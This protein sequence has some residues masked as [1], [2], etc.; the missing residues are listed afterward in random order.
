MSDIIG[1]V[2]INGGG[3]VINVIYVYLLVVCMIWFLSVF[4]V[5]MLVD[6]VGV[7]FDVG[8]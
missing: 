5:D 1:F 7:C 4:C 6:K 2:I 8:V 3:D